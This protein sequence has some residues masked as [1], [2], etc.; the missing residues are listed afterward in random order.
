M[1]EGTQ[2]WPSTSTRVRLVPRLRRFRAATPAS[3]LE[4]APEEPFTVVLPARAGNVI[5]KSMMLAGAAAPREPLLIAPTACA[6][7]QPVPLTP[8][9]RHTTSP[10]AP[11]PP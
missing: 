8:H 10:H 5:A 4:S 7:P 2:R 1:V 11:P 3:P 9:P 6:H